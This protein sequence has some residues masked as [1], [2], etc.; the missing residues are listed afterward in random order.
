[1]KLRTA[2][3]K[4][5]D[6]GGFGRERLMPQRDCLRSARLT[7]QSF[8][9]IIAGSALPRKIGHWCGSCLLFWGAGRSVPLDCWSVPGLRLRSCEFKRDDG[10]V[11][12]HHEP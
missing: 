2:K 6:A 9:D 10:A 5:G 4:T 7:P 3:K 11:L 12:P 8:G 1:M